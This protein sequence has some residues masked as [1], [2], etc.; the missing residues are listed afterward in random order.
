MR[1][2]QTEL[3]CESHE[4]SRAADLWQTGS[5]QGQGRQR[6]RGS[7]AGVLLEPRRLWVKS[8]VQRLCSLDAAAITV[9]R[10]A[11]HTAVRGVRL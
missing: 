3:L 11:T 7:S 4:S 10:E 2:L 8:C 9:G 1:L 5:E 6:E